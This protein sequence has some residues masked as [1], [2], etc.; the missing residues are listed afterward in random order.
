MSPALERI[1][2]DRGEGRPRLLLRVLGRRL[3]GAYSVLELAPQ[4]RRCR[5]GGCLRLVDVPGSFCP[6]H[7]Q[8][9]RQDA[10]TTPNPTAPYA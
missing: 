7:E 2:V 10:M 4:R 9:M 3:E 5:H 6:D 8:V 1:Y